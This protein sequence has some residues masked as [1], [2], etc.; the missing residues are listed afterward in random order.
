VQRLPNT[1]SL[2]SASSATPALCIEHAVTADMANGQPLPPYIED[3]VVWHVVRRAN[4][5][6]TWRRIFLS[7][8]PVT[9][10]RTAPGDQTRHNEK[11]T[12]CR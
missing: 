11:D 3:G 9:D 7:P 2:A 5:R 1:A 6:T 12:T 10:W 8:S 4:G